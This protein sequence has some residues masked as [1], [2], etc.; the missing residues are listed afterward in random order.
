MGF[1]KHTHTC[2]RTHTHIRRSAGTHTHTHTH[3]HK[4]TRTDTL[5]LC[6]YLQCLSTFFVV[7]TDRKRNHKS[8]FS[9]SAQDTSN[10]LSPQ[11]LGSLAQAGCVLCP[12]FGLPR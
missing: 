12:T 3:T 9:S 6:L 2:P 4:R 5:F 1:F 11:F 10:G 8:S 7:T